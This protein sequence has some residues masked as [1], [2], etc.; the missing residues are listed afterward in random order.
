MER[1]GSKLKP[2]EIAYTVNDL[3]VEYF[4][5]V[6]EINFTAEME[7][8]LDEIAN[9]KKDWVDVLKTFYSAFEPRLEHAREDMPEVNAEPEK[10]GKACPAA[11]M[12]SSS[13]GDGMENSSAAVIFPNAST[14]KPTLKR[15]G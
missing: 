10:V 3:L 2:T 1:D 8:D 5:D 11:D 14:P 7:Q 6:L 4:P 9:G 12:I 15:S 13:V